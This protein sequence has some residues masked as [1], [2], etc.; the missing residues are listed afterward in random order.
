MSAKEIAVRLPGVESSKVIDSSD[1]SI[2]LAINGI[3]IA[4]FGLTTQINIKNEEIDR[5]RSKED[6][7]C[8]QPNNLKQCVHKCIEN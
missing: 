2:A 4:S 8:Y 5:Y 6:Q 1:K 3:F 7:I